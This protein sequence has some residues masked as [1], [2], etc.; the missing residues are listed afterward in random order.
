MASRKQI[1]AN[2]KNAQSCAGPTSQAGKAR[3]SQNALKTGI[4]AKSEVIRCESQA[5]YDELIA[6]FY[7]RY[8]PTVPEER[9]LVDALIRSE[10]LSRR[11]ACTEQSVWERGFIET[12]S[13]V[14][15]RVFQRYEKFFDR[16]DRRINSAQ[17]N[18]QK[19]LKQ[20]REIR[21]NPEA[22]PDTSAIPET[23][24]P[25]AAVPDALPESPNSHPETEPLNPELVS[26]LTPA[27]ETPDATQPDAETANLE[28]Q[29]PQKEEIPP[30]AA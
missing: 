29:E 17:R 14:L 26:F 15:G 12:D 18:S 20:L 5:E 1:E 16:L 25:D 6:E 9:L 24:V 2:Q 3:S 22:I 23:I 28:P 21:A 8:H 11:Y 19:A 30:I 13:T 7:A 4:D 27:L 10:W